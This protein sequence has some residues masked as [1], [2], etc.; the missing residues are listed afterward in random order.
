MTP[1][2]DDVRTRLQLLL[3]SP[4]LPVYEPVQMAHT[5]L[6]EVRRMPGITEESAA[7]LIAIA[8]MLIKHGVDLQVER[9]L[10]QAMKR[11]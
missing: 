6:E 2:E 7:M 9:A 3:A 4:S 11:H 10:N 5:L 8:A 1:T